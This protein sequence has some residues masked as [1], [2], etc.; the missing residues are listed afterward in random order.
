MP[1]SFGDNFGTSHW[2]N[3]DFIATARSLCLLTSAAFPSGGLLTFRSCWMLSGSASQRH[4]SSAEVVNQRLS[5]KTAAI[6]LIV[7]YGRSSCRIIDSRS[8][9]V[10]PAWRPVLL[11]GLLRSCWWNPAY[12]SQTNSSNLQT[13]SPVSLQHLI[14]TL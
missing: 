14:H 12:K 7:P 9:Q 8:W 3:H 11:F 6:P 4:D 1:S 5:W 13:T 10:T 2:F